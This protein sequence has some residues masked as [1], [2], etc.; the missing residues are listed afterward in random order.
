[1]KNII[2]SFT[3]LKRQIIHLPVARRK[4]AAA[5][6][7]LLSLS[8]NLAARQSP[9]FQVTQ[10]DRATAELTAMGTP[11]ATPDKIRTTTAT[12]AATDTVSLAT[13]SVNAV[14]TTA[15][16]ATATPVAGYI[17]SETDGM[18]V[19]AAILVMIIIGG[20]L[21]AIAQKPS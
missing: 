21:R 14:T 15:M 2:A 18:I 7:V 6:F 3:R 19:G 4:I 1:M 11:T 20:A 5:I 12:L 17:Q 16:P 13:P 8:I 10:T 9:P